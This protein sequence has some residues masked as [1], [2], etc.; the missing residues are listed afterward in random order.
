ME[1]NGTNTLLE[2]GQIARILFRKR[3][4]EEELSSPEAAQN[5]KRYRELVRDHAMLSKLEANAGGYFR[6]VAD[7]A[8][9]RKLIDDPAGDPELS[10]LAADEIRALEGELPEAERR[11]LMALLPPDPVAERNALMEIRAGTGGDEAALFA[12]DLFRMYSR[13]A[14]NRKWGVTITDMNEGEKGGYKEVV[15]TVTGEGAYAALRFEGGGHRVQRVPETEAQ[16]RIHTSAA[17]VAVFPEADEDDDIEIDPGDLQIDTY[18]A[19][20]AGGQHVNKTDS[21]V[22][23]THR[24]SGIVVACQEERSQPRNKEKCMAMLKTRLLENRLR[25]QQAKI[26]SARKLMVGSGDRSERIRTYNF[27]QNRLTDHRIN[28]TLYSLDRAME[29]DIATLLDT[30]ASTDADERVALELGK[31]AQ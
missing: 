28:L 15:F 20:G 3:H 26:G 14:E 17:T 10:A 22:R 2:E 19:G 12:G 1:R 27:P 13:Y 11:L 5:Q 4:I 25:E 18:R 21:A 29:G 6:L 7:I 24:P 9:H 16:G 31:S 23:V 30:L 8:G